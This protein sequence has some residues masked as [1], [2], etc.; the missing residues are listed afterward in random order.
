MAASLMEDVF[1]LHIII[2]LRDKKGKAWK[3]LRLSLIGILAGTQGE[4]ARGF[5]TRRGAFGAL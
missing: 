1:A 3:K 4:G 2:P 5:G